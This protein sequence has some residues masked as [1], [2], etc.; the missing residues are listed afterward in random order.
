LASIATPCN[1]GDGSPPAKDND[2]LRRFRAAYEPELPV[3]LDLYVKN[4]EITV[5]HTTFNRAGQQFIKRQIDILCSDTCIRSKTF[6]IDDPSKRPPADDPFGIGRF[7]TIPTQPQPKRLPNWSLFRPDAY[8]EIE[9]NWSGDKYIIT[10]VGPGGP[11]TNC[12]SRGGILAL[13]PLNEGYR[14]PLLRFADP[15]IEVLNL[16]ECQWNGRTLT[17]AE[18]REPRDGKF[19]KGAYYFDPKNHWVLYGDEYQLPNEPVKYVT[20][21]E[22]DATQEGPVRLS[23]LESSYEWPD[24]TWLT[25]RYEFVRTATAHPAPSEFALAQFGLSDAPP[26]R[27]RLPA[28]FSLYLPLLAGGLLATMLA[29]AGYAL[30]RMKLSKAPVK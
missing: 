10:R 21:V 12:L 8:Y 28:Q 5:I 6:D 1:G 15:G 18:F 29:V 20:R 11:L 7:A 16:T 19:A 23:K 22:Y 27:E 4:R 3:L 26:A 25:D 2:A 24:K 30:F 17:R 9:G 13:V 14:V